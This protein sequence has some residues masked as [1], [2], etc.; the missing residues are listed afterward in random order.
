MGIAKTF[1]AIGIAVVFAVFVAYGLYVVYEPPKYQYES[2]DCYQNYDCEEMLEK[3]YPERNATNQTAPMP[4]RVPYKNECI[5]EVQSSE[6]YIG[7]RIARDECED[8]FL[9]TT[10]RYKH[11]RNSFWI[12]MFIGIAAIVAGMFLNHLEGIGSGIMAGGILVILWSLGYT[13]EYWFKL[14]KYIKLFMLGVVLVLLIYLGYKR[15][16]DKLD[17][18]DKKSSKR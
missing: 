5:D 15:L 9:Q 1:L 10:A 17:G 12:L 14:N 7:C 2:S 6:E 18:K 3:C 11:S 4:I 16:E 13:A 8:E